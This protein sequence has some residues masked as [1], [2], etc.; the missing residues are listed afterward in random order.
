MHSISVTILKA[1]KEDRIPNMTF[2]D[3]DLYGKRN[4]QLDCLTY[5][6]KLKYFFLLTC[7]IKDML[8][9]TC[10]VYNLVSQ[11]VD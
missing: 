10:R 5:S 6:T 11:P 1:D 4:N 8:S 2:I 3:R 9:T 7:T